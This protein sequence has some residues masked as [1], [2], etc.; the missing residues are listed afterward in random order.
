M[1]TSTDF[2]KLNPH[3]LL[4]HGHIIHRDSDTDSNWKESLESFRFPQTTPTALPITS[5]QAVAGWCRFEVFCVLLRTCKVFYDH[6]LPPAGEPY[7]RINLVLP[8]NIKETD[9]CVKCPRRRQ[10]PNFVDAFF[11]YCSPGTGGLWPFPSNT[12]IRLC[13]HALFLL[14]AIF[15]FP[16]IHSTP[17]M[18]NLLSLE[19]F[20]TLAERESAAPSRSKPATKLW[21]EMM[22]IAHLLVAH[23]THRPQVA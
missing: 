22:T 5:V 1:G 6:V 7:G 8:G 3:N 11:I 21:P 18:A 9:R 23:R 4:L 16:W 14:F 17:L 2:L 13:A 20:A 19:R 12:W 10:F 15:L